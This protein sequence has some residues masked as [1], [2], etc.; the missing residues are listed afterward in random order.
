MI[1][2]ERYPE[3][4]ARLVAE[5]LPYP[6]GQFGGS[7]IVTCAGGRSYFT[8]VWVLVKLLR[9]LG[10]QLPVEVW[11]RG[12]LEMN[13]RM[14]QLLESVPGVKCIDALPLKP[15]LELNGWEIKPFAVINSRFEHV[16]FLD[17]DNVP[18]RDP[19]FLLDSPIYK[20]FGAIFWPD[21]W[22]GNGDDATWR[23]LSDEAWLACGLK[24]RQ[25]PEFESGQMVI[26]KRRCWKTLQ[27][28]LF[29]N[30]HSDR[31]YGLMLGDKD[32][33]HLAWRRVGQEYAMP[34]HRPGQDS[35]LVLYQHDFA[36]RCLFQHRN[37]DKWNYD[38]RNATIPG[39]LHEDLCLAFRDELRC[40]W[41][42]VVRR[43]PMDYSPAEQAAYE[44]LVSSSP[45]GYNTE[46][47]DW[48]LIEFKPDFQIGLG[49]S[50]WETD[51][52]VEERRD[53]GVALV[54]RNDLRKM[55]ILKQADGASWSGRC[56]HFDRAP[57]S[58][59]PMSRL[60]SR[61]R[62]VANQVRHLLRSLP[63][64]GGPA[65]EFLKQT[66]T[67]IYRRVGHGE[68]SMVLGA[69]HTITR[70]A[71]GCERWW[72]I[73]SEQGIPHL[74]IVGDHGRTCALTQRPDGIWR[75][76]WLLFEQMPIELIPGSHAANGPAPSYYA[77]ES[78]SYY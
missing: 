48:R 64:D 1:A 44:H 18:T 46:G 72:F 9:Q 69:D 34:A 50:D 47:K 13:R 54:L 10:C 73:D 52:D 8:C 30:R 55:C 77:G 76:Q 23:T 5:P 49:N 62:E 6:E 16:L 4:I 70:G 41:D 17:A 35:G 61:Q 40:K 3:Q 58:L 20:R 66:G 75:G 51:W 42:G 27:V 37:A 29:L 78:L 32:T 65:G 63:R 45:F 53:G 7:G 19:S 28:A 15:D 59:R 26:D 67:F 25:E 68:R 71:A 24:P 14:M 21:R 31:F 60:P 2:L 12:K 33:F 57:I 74:L 56:L 39:F 43:Y 36:G 22:M 38:G 11:Y